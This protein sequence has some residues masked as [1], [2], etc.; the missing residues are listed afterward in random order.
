MVFLVA[1][2]LLFALAAVFCLC[3][4]VLKKLNHGLQQLHGDF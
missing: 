2:S 3:C 4:I 1:G